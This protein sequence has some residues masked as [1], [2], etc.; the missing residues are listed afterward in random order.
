MQCFPVS[1]FPN[2]VK[3]A[4]LRWKIRLAPDSVERHFR[5]L[6]CTCP[7]GY[8]MTEQ[9]RTALVAVVLAA[10]ILLSFVLGSFGGQEVILP[11]ATA[12]QDLFDTK[13]KTPQ[14][15]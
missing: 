1:Q 3:A 7:S 10:F 8:E 11:Y 9:S 6:R 15:Q 14:A 5:Q 4:A 12:W 2:V 13:A